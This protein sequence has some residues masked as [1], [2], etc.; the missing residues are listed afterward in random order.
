MYLIND[1]L[2]SG[3]GIAIVSVNENV[4][5]DVFYLP[6]NL[7]SKAD[8][9]KIKNKE[10]FRLAEKGDVYLGTFDEEIHFVPHQFLRY[11]R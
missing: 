2:F 1:D 8:F 9:L 6:K 10:I 11:R 7:K 5:N 3:G 4:I